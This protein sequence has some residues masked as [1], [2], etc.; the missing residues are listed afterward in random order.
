MTGAESLIQ[1]L[2]DGGVD[3]CF[4]N[5]G[6]SEINFVSA[7][8][9]HP[10]MR[11]VLCLFEGVVTGCA[12]GYARMAGKPAASL[13]HLGPGLGNGIANLH[14]AKKAFTP[15]VNIVGQHAMRHLEY[16]APLSCDIEGLAHPVSGWVKTT[17]DATLVAKDG[18]AAIAASQSP[19]G[20]VATLILP[21]DTAWNEAESSCEP[22]PIQKPNPVPSDRI[23]EIAH[24]IK[25]KENV[26]LLVGDH[27]LRSEKLQRIT[28]SIAKKF[29]ARFMAKWFGARI[30]RGASR[31]IIERLAYVVDQSLEILKGTEHLVLIGTVEPVGFFAYPNKPSLLAPPAAEKHVF[32]NLNDD[33]EAALIALAAKLEVSDDPGELAILDRPALPSGKLD[34]DK[35]WE[36]VSALMPENSIVSDEGVTASRIAGPLTQNAP[37][38][39]WLHVT[40]GAIGQGLPVATGAAV[41]APD[42]QVF[43]MEADGSGMYTLQALWTQARE[44]LNVVN[45]IFANRA[46]KILQVEMKKLCDKEDGPKSSSMMELD[47][48][49]LD[50]VQLSQGMGVPAVSVDTAEAF[51]E[52]LK[53]GIEQSGPCLIEA[54]V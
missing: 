17:T 47:N 45:I 40:G 34:P 43:A 3:T 48:P 1:T 6:T 25:T 42:R 29:G 28:S 13:L 30:K 11:S 35:I 23:S 39:D 37:A 54:L 4:M 41:A 20:Q 33:V 53:R 38:H 2:L 10:E 49:N 27:V 26:V 31:P 32:A 8:D 19:P 15:M 9:T 50:W 7:L 52:A 36:S 24:I 14:N 12:D 46:Y 5:P 44:S 18:A 22:Q 51:N 21:A 16:D